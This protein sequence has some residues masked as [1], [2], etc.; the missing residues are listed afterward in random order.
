MSAKKPRVSARG[1]AWSDGDA[2][3][4]EDRASKEPLGHLAR[5][6]YAGGGL[7]ALKHY[8]EASR[9]ERAE[10]DAAYALGGHV[11]VVEL[12]KGRAP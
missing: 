5:A 11:A 3:A 6:I 8:T 4:E 9:E 1:A 10:L 12:V 2:A 7:D